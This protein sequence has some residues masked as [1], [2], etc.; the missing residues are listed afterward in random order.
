MASRKKNTPAVQQTSPVVESE[1]TCQLE[2][3]ECPPI[4]PEEWDKVAPHIAAAGRLK[5]L[6]RSS[7]AV[8]CA[9]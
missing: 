9:A 3:V 2:K 4:A 7:L 1:Q 6:D 5:P 8:Y